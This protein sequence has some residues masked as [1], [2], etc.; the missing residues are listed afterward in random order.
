MIESRPQRPE[1]SGEDYTA[2]FIGDFNPKIYQPAWF[3]S[4]G[5]LRESEAEAA[6]IEIIHADFTSFSTDWFV[7]QVARERFSMT[8][9]SSAYKNHLRDFVLGT[10][11][12]LSHTPIKQMG[13]NYGTHVRFKSENDWHCFGH[14]LVPKSPWSGLLAKPGMRS[15]TVEGARPDDRHGHVTVTAE[16]IR[17]SGNEVL[18][19]VND[20]CELHADDRSIGSGYFLEIIETDY[21]QIMNRSKA[22]VDGLLERFVAQQSFDNGEDGGHGSF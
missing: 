13:L 20:H 3:A 4:Q 7:M 21:E 8:V 16:P 6:N 18:L 5:L 22:M 9:K 11:H 10:F 12:N 14:F 15:V 2:V 17:A 1:M 19:R